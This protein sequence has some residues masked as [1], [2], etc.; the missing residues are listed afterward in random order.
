MSEKP[1]ISICIPTC[2]G[3]KFI[4]ETI[5]SVLNQTYHISRSMT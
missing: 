2:N 5:E 4:A 3:G 1:D